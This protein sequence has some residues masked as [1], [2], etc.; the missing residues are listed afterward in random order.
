M[1]SRTD[2]VAVGFGVKP[3]AILL[4]M[5]LPVACT[6]LFQ[7]SMPGEAAR[8]EIVANATGGLRVGS[9]ERDITPEVGEYLGGF[10]IARTSTAIGSPL[11]VRALVL[12]TDARRFAIVGVDNLGLMREDVDYIK[13]GVGGFAN[14]DV[15]VCSSHT[16]AGPDPIGL[17][18]YYFLTTGRDVSYV[19]RVRTAVRE[20]VAE[21]H[22]NAAPADLSHGRA[23][24][25]DAGLVKN[26][27]RRFVF[28]RRIVVLHARARDD[29]RPLG[30][31]LHF[32]CHPEV[33]PRRNTLASADFVGS[34]CD[35]WRRRGHGQAVFVNGALGA[36]ISPDVRPRDMSG[37]RTFGE[38]ACDLCERALARC[39]TAG[40][41]G[42]RGAPSRCLSADGLG[43]VPD[44]SA[45][46]VAAARG[47]RRPCAQHGR[48]P[49]HR[50]VR[51]GRRAG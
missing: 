34:L 29:G 46:D 1:A 27:N 6:G 39:R 8:Y 33:L 11:R 2:V 51:G 43:G 36:M 47:L 48:L 30:S 20:A 49:A 15:F 25:P 21:A 42:G 23:L 13:S 4:L 19:Q 5:M 16:H 32:A 24:L 17:W 50:R 12:E 10:D 26:A 45:D 22:H 7:R 41:R 40:R 14:G 9:A 44:R 28:D 31:L 38:R 35:E 37:V 18:G 3:I